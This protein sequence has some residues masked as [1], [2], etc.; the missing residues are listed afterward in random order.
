[1]ELSFSRAR[2][3]QPFFIRGDVIVDATRYTTIMT[4]GLSGHVWTIKGLIER[5][6][7]EIQP[8]AAF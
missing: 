7:R 8:K 2:P 4:S 1:M 3:Q 5:G 6:K